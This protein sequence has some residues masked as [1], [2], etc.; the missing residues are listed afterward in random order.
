MPTAPGRPRA[1]APPASTLSAAPLFLTHCRTQTHPS[2]YL[3][4]TAPGILIK[5]AARSS[6][7]L[8]CTCAPAATSQHHEL[9][10][11]PGSQ[12]GPGVQGA[13]GY[14]SPPTDAFGRT[15]TVL[16]PS[17]MHTWHAQQPQSYCKQPPNNVRMQESR[18][19]VQD[20]KTKANTNLKVL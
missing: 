9:L 20:L 11:E 19:Y 12:A 4:H 13:H 8:P 17:R 7:F 16:H 6:P 15:C 3:T 5:H 18:L 2:W 1:P 10:Q 14:N